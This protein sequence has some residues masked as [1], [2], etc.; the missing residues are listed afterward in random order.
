[1]KKQFVTQ[2]I[3]IAVLILFCLYRLLY[4][5]ESV[6]LNVFSPTSLAVDLN[7]NRRFDSDELICISGIETFSENLS[8]YNEDLA[9]TLGVNEK[10]A[11]AL[12]YLTRD[13]SVTSL[14]NK[15]VKFRADEVQKNVDCRSGDVFIDN[16]SYRKILLDEGLAY[17][18]T[19]PYNDVKL[20]EHIASA[21]LMEPV[22]LNNKSK[23]YHTIGCKFGK[24]AQDYSILLKDDLPEGV[25]PCKWCHKG[26]SLAQETVQPS[27]NVYPDRIFDGEIKMYLTDMTNNLKLRDDC[28]SNIC[29]A[30]LNEINNAERSIDIAAYGWVS[31]PEIDDAVKS[32][33]AR[34]VIV[35]MVYDFSARRSYYPDTAKIAR[36]ASETKNDL[37]PGDSRMS[38]Y[39]MHNKFMIF[40][41]KKVATGSLNY[42]KTDFSEF[43]SNFIFFINSPDVAKIY[44]GEFEQMLSGRFHTDKVKREQYSTY[45]IGDSEIQVYFSPQDNAITDKVLDY[46]NH[47]KKY[48]YMPVFVI[49]H[50]PLEAALLKAKARGVDVKLIVDATNV[51]AA[52]SSVKTLRSNGIP[53]KVENYAGKLHSK[54]IIIDDEYILAGSM[55]FSRSGESRND[56]NILII[57]NPRLAVFY[58]DFFN[59][60]WAKIP[61]V[62]LVRSPRA[63]SVESIGSCFDGIDN[64]FDGKIDNIDEGCFGA[65]GLK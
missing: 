12:A 31:I 35:R 37:K 21:K 3:F 15:I 26:N 42:S 47:A 27:K 57:K 13:Y 41:G 62:Y 40:D 4:N 1:M 38:E 7:G 43:N 30:F 25:V 53:V 50:K 60:L 54:S 8:D 55:N 65:K 11:L 49:T 48:I 46:V 32:A 19:F 24:S 44:T 45:K 23:K 9:K 5:V 56:E 2:L 18:T 22:I 29:Q 59:Y 6:V 33:V 58:K 20:K 61:E 10:G 28:S 36:Y 51:Y 16:V 17:S 14:S 34:G 64:D 39:L 52:K 63:E